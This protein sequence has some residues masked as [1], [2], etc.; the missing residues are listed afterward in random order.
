MQIEQ[1]ILIAFIMFYFYNEH[2]T[3]IYNYFSYKTLDLR[4]NNNVF[5]LEGE[6][7][8][9]NY[10]KITSKKNKDMIIIINSNG[11]NLQYGGK[12]INFLDANNI[13]CV[14]IK[15]SSTAFDIFQHNS[16]ITK[17]ITLKELRSIC[18]TTIDW[19][20]AFDDKFNTYVAKKIDLSIKEYQ[21][22]IDKN[23]EL[24]SGEE[25]I[26]NKLADEIINLK[27]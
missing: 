4:F 8:L 9:I 21:L 17:K 10:L 12:I 16:V 23:W 26:K 11:G 2:K 18:E 3:F 5:M 13:T 1:Y 27:F 19:I 25:C 15:A 22:K 20:Q 7:D 6:I 14:T 24:N